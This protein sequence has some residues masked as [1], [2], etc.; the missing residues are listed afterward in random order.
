MIVRLYISTFIAHC[1]ELYHTFK[2]T[3]Q[4]YCDKS[5][6]YELSF[7]ENRQCLQP[8]GKIDYRNLSLIVKGGL[9]NKIQI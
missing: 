5:P 4:E 2:I 1:S 9:E 8:K 6:F 3:G 7:E